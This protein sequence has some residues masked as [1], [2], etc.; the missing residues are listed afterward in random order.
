MFSADVE[1]S[2]HDAIGADLMPKERPADIPEVEN[3]AIVHAYINYVV[4]EPSDVLAANP[5]FSAA[6]HMPVTNRC[7][8]FRVL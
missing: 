1:I 7:P 6:F 5:V 3:M 2:V 4:T 8:A